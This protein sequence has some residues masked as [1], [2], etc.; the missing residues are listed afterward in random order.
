MHPPLSPGCHCLTPPRGC[1]R[2]RARSFTL[3]E[4]LMTAGN[5]HQVHAALVAAAMA[6]AAPWLVH[7]QGQ[8]GQVAIDADDI[9]G[10]GA[11]AEGPQAGG[12]GDVRS[13]ETPPQLLRVAGTHDPARSV[14]PGRP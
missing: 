1:A 13:P 9:G 12:G 5:R 10:G 7:T 8:G 11:P 2:I 14:P 6:C 3:E 4:D